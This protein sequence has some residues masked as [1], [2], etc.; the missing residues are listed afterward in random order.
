VNHEQL[1]SLIQAIEPL[2]DRETADREDAITWLESDAPIYRIQ[3]PDVPP[4]HLVSYFAIVDPG[5]RKM[6]LQDHLLAKRWIPA[7]G[8]VDPDEDPAET[9][10]RECEEELGFAAKFLGAPDPHFITVTT[11]N[12]QGNHTDVS[13]WY[14]LQASEATPL[15]IEEGKFAEIRWWDVDKILSS[16]I[17][18]F[19]PELHRFINKIQGMFP[20]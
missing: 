7:G 4:K 15:V 19:D 11:T 16:S 13:L 18:L 2:D 1:L 5:S 17:E 14:V 3:K 20:A 9:V 12:G 6:L 8:H 10:R